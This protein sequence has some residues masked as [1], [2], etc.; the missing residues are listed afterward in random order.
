MHVHEQWIS[1]LA[2]LKAAKER[3]GVWTEAEKEAE[4]EGWGRV[5]KKKK[6]NREAGHRGTIMEE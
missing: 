5:G 6:N 3:P 1:N 4:V 2:D